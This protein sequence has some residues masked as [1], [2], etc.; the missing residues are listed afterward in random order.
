MLTCYLKILYL[1]LYSKVIQN[2][3]KNTRQKHFHSE[4]NWNSTKKMFAVLNLNSLE[5]WNIGITGK[6]G[7]HSRGY[8]NAKKQEKNTS[9]K[10]FSYRLWNMWKTIQFVTY[11]ISFQLSHFTDHFYIKKLNM[12]PNVKMNLYLF[13]SITNDSHGNYHIWKITKWFTK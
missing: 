13:T 5:I 10:F 3:T 9:I 11:L 4:E 8:W 12:S 1:I 7:A 2:L 6:K